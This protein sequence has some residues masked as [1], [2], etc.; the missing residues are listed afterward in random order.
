M[1]SVCIG[2]VVHNRWK[3]TE[4]LI[5]FLLKNTEYKDFRITVVDNG[6]FD[7]TV[8]ELDQFEN[9]IKILH[10]E[11]QSF[12]NCFNEILK[13]DSDFYCFIT[14]EV[15]F[16]TNDWLQKLV[17][18]FQSDP[19]NCVCVPIKKIYGQSLIGGRLDHKAQCINVFKDQFEELEWVHSCC[20]LISK[21][22]LKRIG[23]FDDRFKIR[24]Y[25]EIDYCIRILENK[26]KLVYDE[27][28]EILFYDN[29]PVDL[30]KC[31][32]INRQLF[33]QKHKNWLIEN[34]QKTNKGK[35]K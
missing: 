26:Y 13:D 12:A 34:K 33:I 3:E 15:E 14:N 8:N 10:L 17:T 1:N 5:N 29:E 7:E 4:K 24:Y 23:L 6:S 2:I 22:T 21:M 28:V 35:S 20:F 19:M 9:K 18:K 25:E 27:N 31:Q 11:K 30:K 16:V 32:E